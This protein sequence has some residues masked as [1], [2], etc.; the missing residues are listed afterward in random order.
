M[1]ELKGTHFDPALLD[2]FYTSA[3]QFDQL[4]ELNKDL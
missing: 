3:T 1:M 2:V 4:Y